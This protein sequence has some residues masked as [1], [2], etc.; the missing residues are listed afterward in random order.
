MDHNPLSAAVAQ[1]MGQMML[2]IL[3]LQVQL[4]QLQQAQAEA[5]GKVKKIKP[6]A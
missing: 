2:Q 4:Q 1:Q 3:Q 6:A 5:S